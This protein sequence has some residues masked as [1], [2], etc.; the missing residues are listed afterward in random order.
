ADLARAVITGIWPLVMEQF[1][2]KHGAPPGRGAV[3]LGMGSLGASRLNAGSDLDLIVIYDAGDVEG[4]DGRRPLAARPY[5]ARLTQAMITALT[6]PMAE[7]RLYEVDMRLRPSGNQG[8][9]ATSWPSFQDYQQSDAWVW[10]H[11]ALTRAQVLA[12]EPGLAGDVEA[13]RQGLMRDKGDPE[14]VLAQVS[15]MRGRIA[16]AKAPAGPWDA[17]LGPGRLME[18]ELIAEAGTLMAGRGARD[19]ASGFDGGVAIGWLD[20]GDRDALAR[21]YAI[22]WQ[23]QMVARLISDKPLD[24]ALMGEGGAAF[25]LRE[26]GQE[27]LARLAAHLGETCIRAAGVIDA[28]LER[29]PK[30]V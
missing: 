14:A 25:L 9:V 26:T 30:K 29:L 12:G 16:S 8:P 22:C 19:V 24:P 15:E 1:G 3:V 5:Y 13:F 23:V 17:K 27:D 4:S 2:A 11:L 18:L 28:A 10:E 20:D 21:A 7:G 6:A